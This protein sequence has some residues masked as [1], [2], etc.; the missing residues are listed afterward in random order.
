[1]VVRTQCAGR[2]VTGLYIG[3]RNV[4]RNFPRHT[5][6]IEVE[7][8]HLHIHCDLKPVFWRDRPEI[9]DERLCAWLED[10]LYHGR[11]CRAPLPLAL[12]P[13][14]NNLYKLR[15]LTL[16]PVSSAAHAQTGL[17][18]LPS[19]PAG[20]RRAGD[21]PICGTS[22]CRMRRYLACSTQTMW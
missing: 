16:P 14:G 13:A 11:S 9:H 17:T 7:L 21:S 18:I 2:E 1:M 8:G 4:R 22:P 19:R 6:A 12:I 15:P 3:A 5:A 10:R 20:P